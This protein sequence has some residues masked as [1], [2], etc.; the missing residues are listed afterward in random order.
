V[1]VTVKAEKANVIVPP[2]RKNIQWKVEGGT[3][4]V[5]GVRH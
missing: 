4:E 3:Q 5:E 2:G 1:E